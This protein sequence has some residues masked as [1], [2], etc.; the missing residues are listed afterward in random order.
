MTAMS[1][2]QRQVRTPLLRL[3][4][5]ALSFW[6][7]LRVQIKY[8]LRRRMVRR[9]LRQHLGQIRFLPPLSTP[10]QFRKP[11]LAQTA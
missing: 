3:Q 1:L 2:R 5:L 6:M 10:G 11:L 8:P 9:S 4:H 7:G